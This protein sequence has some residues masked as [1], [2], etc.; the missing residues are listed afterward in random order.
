MFSPYKHFNIPPIGLLF[1]KEK[2]DII[3]NYKKQ[4]KIWF[5][6]KILK[7]LIFYRSKTF[8]ESHFW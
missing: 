2:L 8:G 1:S 4:N 6:K 7:R 3:S 5:F